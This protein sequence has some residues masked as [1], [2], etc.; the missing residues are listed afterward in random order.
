MKNVNVRFTSPSLCVHYPTQIMN[1]RDALGKWKR[2]F[3]TASVVR[4]RSKER[5]EDWHYQR[6][7][8]LTSRLYMYINWI[9]T[10]KIFFYSKKWKVSPTKKH[11]WFYFL[12]FNTIYSTFKYQNKISFPIIKF[13]FPLWKQYTFAYIKFFKQLLK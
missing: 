1:T 8:M 6:A 5:V 12:I 2:A 7:I 3:K 9:Y 13:P 10:N 11:L 4:Y